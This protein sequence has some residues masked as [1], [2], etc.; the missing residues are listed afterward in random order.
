MPSPF[1]ESSEPEEPSATPQGEA[2]GP[3]PVAASSGGTDAVTPAPS[4]PPP[5]APSAPSGEG[6]KKKN[7]TTTIII[8]VVAVLLV[9]CC[10]C[11]ISIFAFSGFWEEL[12]W[13]LEG[14]WLAS[15]FVRPLLM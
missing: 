13:Q 3:G 7:N 2:P 1:A 5:Q 6:E 10:C 8:I 9:L 12:R 11:I 14:L 15:S 4:A